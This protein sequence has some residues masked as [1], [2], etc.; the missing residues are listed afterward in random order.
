MAT[1][2]VGTWILVA[3]VVG[4]FFVV[5]LR[6]LW[7]QVWQH[8][9]LAASAE[10]NR[11]LRQI[12]RAPRGLIIDREGEI[13]AGNEQVYLATGVE[14][15]RA[16]EWPIEK[17][18]ALVRMATEPAS[19]RTRYKRTYPWGPV[20]AHIIG[21]V[22]SLQQSGAVVTGRSGIE[23]LKQTELA[24]KDGVTIYERNA[25]GEATRVLQQ[26]PAQ[27]GERLSLTLDAKL[28]EVAFEALGARRGA[29]VVGDP[30]TGEILAMVSTPSFVP[31]SDPRRATLDRWKTAIEE[32]TI[33][34][35]IP[36][37]LDFPNNPF[38]FRPLAAQYPPGSIFKII[39]ALAGLEYG[40]IT[41]DTQVR[42]EGALKVG[43]FEY[44]NWY[45]RQFGRVEGEIAIERALARSN[46]I[47]FYKTA[48]WVG[49]ERLAQF[50]RLFS[51]G[52]PTQQVLPG[53]R[54]GLVP[55]PTW[56]QQQF[57]ERWF[58]GNTYHMGIGQGD[59]LTTPLQLH[60]VM[61]TVAMKGRKC[62][63]QFFLNTA[64]SCSEVSLS[65]ES[66]EVIVRGLRG[67]CSPGGTAFP[68][69]ETPYDVMCKTGTAEFGSADEQGH[70]P[71]HGWF[72][73]AISRKGRAAPSTP[74]FSPDIVVTVIVESDEEEPFREGSRDA[75]PIAKQVVD[76]WFA[77]RISNLQQ[78]AP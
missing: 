22:D 34:P 38:L 23:R 43:D 13:V 21:Y 45:W 66:L 65:E 1:Q 19:V 14:N 6:L 4:L 48:E 41:P 40:A 53:E 12:T 5:A 61:S 55:D 17:E 51:L 2:K 50:A 37:A 27:P 44:E 78:V 56:K 8:G 70:R 42:D 72:S 58:L 46:D 11:L 16:V 36:A 24:G 57:G 69:F 15:G 63:P 68:F 39:T 77:N 47:F 7:L 54:R 60:T 64:G 33:A 71:T 67:A 52:E 62:S 10:R 29:V 9:P 25:F 18:E 75:A 3:A 49:P 20:L 28:S 26:R 30:Q 31:E 35:S 76:W 74:E 73:A 32:K 59:V